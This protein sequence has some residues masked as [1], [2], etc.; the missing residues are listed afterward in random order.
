MGDGRKRTV[1]VG[2]GH[3][4]SGTRD[5]GSEMASREQLM[6]A[7]CADRV[8]MFICSNSVDDE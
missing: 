4:R 7:G 8:S 1:S 2:S 6:K 5:A 3:P